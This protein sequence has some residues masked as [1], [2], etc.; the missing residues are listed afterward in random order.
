[1]L[2]RH[3]EIRRWN[4]DICVILAARTSEEV[5]QLLELRQYKAVYV[6][7]DAEIGFFSDEVVLN[8]AP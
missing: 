8:C 2:F 6:L 1:M 4:G 5:A 3:N 7:N